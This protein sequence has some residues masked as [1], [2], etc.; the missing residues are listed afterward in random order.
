MRTEAEIEE[1]S[2]T[3]TSE[4]CKFPDSRINSRV[5]GADARF[6][7]TPIRNYVT[8]KSGEAGKLFCSTQTWLIQ[9]LNCAL[10]IGKLLSTLLI[11]TWIFDELQD[12]I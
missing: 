9:L 5:N 6:N 3:Q 2:N 8:L 4:L 10:I 12:Q 7:L 1:K 11:K